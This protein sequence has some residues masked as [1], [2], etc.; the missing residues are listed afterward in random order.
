MTNPLIDPQ[1]FQLQDVLWV[2]HCA[3]GP[4]PELSAQAVQELLERELKPWTLRWREDFVGLPE[5]VRRAGAILLGGQAEDVSLCSSTNTAL[6]T[7]AHGFDFERGDE[8]LTSV[9]E[10]PSNTWPWRSLHT[11]GV[12]HR[13]A[14]LWPGHRAGSAA[15]DS[16]PPPPEVD[17]ETQ[18]IAQLSERTRLVSVSWVRFQDGLVLDLDRLG[19]ELA[20]RGIPLV[21]DGVQ[22]AGTLRPN[23]THCA[24]LA[25]GGHKGLLAPQGLGLLWTAPA[26]RQ[27]LLP[28]G[29]WLSVDQATDF[30][31]ASTDLGREFYTDGRRLESGVPNLIGAAALG[32]SLEL[33]N[34]VGVDAITPHVA[35][36]R[37]ELIEQLSLIPVWAAEADRLRALDRRGRLGALIGLHHQGHGRESLERLVRRGLSRQIYASVREGYLRIALHGWH[38]SRDIER[39][40]TW[41]R[42]DW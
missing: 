10:F 34:R 31:R 38:S 7:I 20:L 16:T 23:L 42:T 26:F 29:G 14:P 1:E 13:E 2:M 11:R 28:Q 24:A 32:S 18:L 27:Q 4:I 12:V 5:R 40:S 33:L 17:P 15:W 39:L 35:R 9:G 25:A 37:A 6:V 36:L 30:A 8:V 3:E 22:G 21:V 41:L 19:A